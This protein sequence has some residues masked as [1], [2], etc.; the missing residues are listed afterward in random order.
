MDEFCGNQ[1]TRPE[2]DP[3]DADERDEQTL[4]ENHMSRSG[5]NGTVS[6]MSRAILIVMIV[7]IALLPAGMAWGQLTEE[8]LAAIPAGPQP[9]KFSH[10]IH[11][12]DN[13]IPCEYCHIYARRSL[14]S[15]VPPVAI[16]MGCHKFIA[17]GLSEVQK[18]AKYW[19]EKK[20]IPWVKIHDVPDFVRFPHFRHV[21]AQNEVFPNGVPCQTCHGPIETMHVV[22]KFYPDFGEMGWCLDC[23]LTIPGSIE[24][25]MA[26]PVKAGSSVLK[27]AKGPKGY[28]RPN[29]TDCL[30]CHK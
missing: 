5:I 3:P 23:H 25:K 22:E 14:V 29:L 21:R 1:I 13:E 7:M 6:A 12:T 17:T 4:S 20:P 11:A 2:S 15:G 30:T 27:N 26:I 10:K 9:I 8:D 28:H 24:R 16:C 19:Q 18:V